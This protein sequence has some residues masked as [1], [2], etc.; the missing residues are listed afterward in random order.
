MTN[1]RQALENF[2]NVF[3][4]HPHV[5]SCQLVAAYFHSKAVASED[6]KQIEDLVLLQEGKNRGGNK[7][8]T[9]HSLPDKVADIK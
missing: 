9:Q 4:N 5:R 8:N 2:M 1:R 3:L 6:N 7:T